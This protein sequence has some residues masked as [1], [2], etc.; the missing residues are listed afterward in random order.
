MIGYDWSV[1]IKVFNV[2]KRELNATPEQA[3][4]LI[5]SLASKEDALWP[6]NSWPRMK[7]DR[8]LQIGAEGGHG[9][10]RYFVKEYEPGRLITFR[11][12]SPKGFDGFHGYEV[13]AVP[14]QS[15]V[16]RHT[17]R[18]TARFPATVTWPVIFRPLHNALMED[19]LATAQ[20]SLGHHPQ[21]SPWSPWVRFLRWAMSGGKANKQMTPV[22]CTQGNQT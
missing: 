12:T 1:E 5:N 8:T 10:I 16:L 17:L 11:F 19:S 15:V 20:A 2:H 14:G 7:F 22:G 3:G 13:I 18:M 9:P 6:I 4:A 21:M